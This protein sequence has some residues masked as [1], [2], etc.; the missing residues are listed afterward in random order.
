MKR[1]PSLQPLSDDHHAALVLARRLRR[2]ALETAPSD[3]E[4]LAGEV[5]ETFGAELEPHFRVEEEWLFPAL[6]QRG[7]PELV[8]RAE[9]DHVRLRSLV[10]GAWKPGTAR[11]IGVLLE[12]HVRFEERVLFPKAESLLSEEGLAAVRAGWGRRAG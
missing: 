11:E 9:E 8:E 3:V 10:G 4:S 1:H 12:K 5:R 7:A 6:A 2:L